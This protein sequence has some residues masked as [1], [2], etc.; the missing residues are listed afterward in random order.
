[1]QALDCW[2]A[3]CS[4]PFGVDCC[5]RLVTVEELGSPF[6]A[7]VVR[8]VDRRSVFGSA[9]LE[10]RSRTL[11]ASVSVFRSLESGRSSPAPVAAW[12]FASR[13]P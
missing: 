9:T 6:V 2:N 5:L 11:I 10:M 8:M 13:D 1:V 7:T 3:V 12:V 4:S